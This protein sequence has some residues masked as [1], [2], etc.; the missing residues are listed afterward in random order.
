MKEI[1]PLHELWRL[2]N[3]LSLSRVA[4]TPVVGYFLAKGDDRSTLICVAL[5]AVAGITDGLD[6]YFA[7][8]MGMVSNLGKM[9]DPLADKLMAAVL[10]VL[11]ILFRE[12]PVWLA[13]VIVGRDVLIVLAGSLLLR[14]KKLVLPSNLTGKYAFA[15]IVVLLASYVVRFEFGIVTTTWITVSLVTLSTF[16]YGRVFLH[17]RRGQTPPVFTD[18][19]LFAALRIGVVLVYAGI[20]FFKLAGHY[21]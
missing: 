13:V 21:S 19:P 11:L 10:V 3:L 16:F 14:G 20:F 15:A 2:P 18:R 8:R 4:L 5:L 12:F 1:M 6:G 17:V 7:R 9:L